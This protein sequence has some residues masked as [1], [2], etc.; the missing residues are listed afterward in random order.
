MTTE[1]PR[2]LEDVLQHPHADTSAQRPATGLDPGARQLIV[3]VVEDIVQSRRG[4]MP[5]PELIVS[6][7][8]SDRFGGIHDYLAA[9]ESVWG[10]Q[11]RFVLARAVEEAHAE[12]R[13]GPN[14]LTVMNPD[15]LANTV[16]AATLLAQMPEP[17]FRMA[18][19]VTLRYLRGLEQAAER[20][21]A[22]CQ[23]RGAPWRIDPV[24]GF[25]WVGDSVIER[26]VIQPALTILNDPRFVAGVR[27]EFDQALAELKIGTPQTRKQALAEAS[28][29]V[30]SAMKVVLIEHGIGHAPGDAA[31][32]LFESLRDKGLVASSDEC[33]IVAVPRA[34]NKRGGHGGGPVAHDVGQAEAEAFIAAAATAIVF[35]GKL[36]P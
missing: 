9:V 10:G 5:T 18:I 22:I 33:L 19:E 30:E 20:L 11:T 27:V 6:C 17:D 29:A 1:A 3:R 4:Q 25:I 24:E 8:F 35:L 7:Y 12:T 13:F 34:R 31:Q 16:A 26:E 15:L 32:K 28:N 21:T 2:I 14:S 36:L 23:S